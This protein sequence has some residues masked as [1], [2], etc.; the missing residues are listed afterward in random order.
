MMSE[1]IRNQIKTIISNSNLDSNE[2]NALKNV[3]NEVL[4]YSDERFLEL[5]KYIMNQEKQ[6]ITLQIYTVLSNPED[7]INLFPIDSVENND[8]TIGVFFKCSYDKFR[9]ICSVDN[10]MKDYSVV[11]KINNQEVE[12]KIRFIVK[13]RYVK[14]EKR[15]LHRIKEQ[16][17][18]RGPLIFSPYSRRYAE[19]DFED[20][21][22]SIKD[23]KKIDFK[24][25]SEFIEATT[26]EKCLKWNLNIDDR[27]N[28]K[29]IPD[30]SSDISVEIIKKVFGAEVESMIP[31]GVKTNKKTYSCEKN[32]FLLFHCGKNIERLIIKK[33]DDKL[34]ALYDDDVQVDAI[35]QITVKEPDQNFNVDNN[36]FSNKTN[37]YY[38]KKDR[39]LSYADI[40][41][42]MNAFRNNDLH[43]SINDIGI[44]SDTY[45]KK[46]SY[47]I[48]HEYDDDLRYYEN[49]SLS[50]LS[51]DH[52]EKVSTKNITDKH[53]S[54]HSDEYDSKKS[55]TIPR[56]KPIFCVVDFAGDHCFAED[57]VR[58]VIE[59]LKE[60]YPEFIWVGELKE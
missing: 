17:G 45:P 22:I 43:I 38:L 19:I 40:N 9:E 41:Y 35:I 6:D 39:L 11:I 59:F 28:R 15:Y 57:Y 54:S 24:E 8:E 44:Y 58:F 18:Y 37:E 46:E 49:F 56:K 7:D 47:R 12:T 23:I 50:E 55:R 53:N 21:S 36:V 42:I 29:D 26:L 20:K 10:M 48:I 60:K 13:D 34:Y 52:V 1:K 51:L 30:W 5:N 4:N 31:G 3:M 27:T 16:Y 33:Y 14:A 2:K 32:K 25:L